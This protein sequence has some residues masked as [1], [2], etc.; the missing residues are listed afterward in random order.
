MQKNPVAILIGG[1]G[2]MLLTYW[3]TFNLGHS[4]AVGKRR[5]AWEQ[6]NVRVGASGSPDERAALARIA[7][8]LTPQ[9]AEVFDMDCIRKGYAAL[10]AAG[11]KTLAETYDRMVHG[12][13]DAGR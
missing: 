10:Q 6:V 2:L 8:C 1:I 11:N 3:I 5:Q 13:V 7:P 12:V 9:G 4:Q